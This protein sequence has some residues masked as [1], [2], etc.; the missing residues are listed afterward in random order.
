MSDRER[1]ADLEA[2]Q[3]KVGEEIVEARRTL[4]GKYATIVLDLTVETLTERE[5]RDLL[6][7]AIRLG[8]APALAMLSVK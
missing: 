6:V 4:R 8:G 2:R 1:L 5:F 7:Q 3:R